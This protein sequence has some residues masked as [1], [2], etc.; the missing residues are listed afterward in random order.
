MSD[1]KITIISAADYKYF[2]L[3][4]ELIASVRAQKICETMDINILDAGL[5]PENRDELQSMNVGVAQADWPAPLTVSKMQGRDYIKACVLR[6]F[7]N[8]IFPGYDIYIWL[9]SDTWI[10]T[11]EC[12]D[13]F[14]KGANKDRMAC[15]IL[16]D[17]AFPKAARMK[18]LG[19]LP[20]KPKSFYYSN[21]KKAFGG[22][23]ARTLFG[24][25]VVSAGAFGLKAAAP[26]WQAWQNLITKALES[27][28]P[29]T[30]EQLSLGV[31]AHIEN[32]PMEYLPSTCNWP[33]E[34]PVLWDE[35]SKQFVEPYLPHKPI[36]LMHL[37]GYDEMRLDPSVKTTIKTTDNGN[38]EMSLRYGHF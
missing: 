29:F 30:A 4:K 9:D 28:N 34:F 37:S 19:N 32:L 11:P 5:T 24:Y 31:M 17:R 21:A 16:I 3:L 18:W 14:V 20:F 8:Q 25:N 33:L 15:T 12:I 27:G 7:I 38:K 10:Q 6:P 23:T 35:N 2:P 13:L 26:H 36:S 22:K 1:Q